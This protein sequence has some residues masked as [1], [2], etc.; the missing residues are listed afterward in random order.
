MTTQQSPLFLRIWE[1]ISGSTAFAVQNYYHSTISSGGVDYQFLDFDVD[2]LASTGNADA[3]DVTVTMPAL[4]TAVETASR[5]TGQFM[6]TLTAYWFEA[7]TAPETPPGGQ[8][9]LVQFVGL[10]SSWALPNFDS[11]LTLTI[12]SPLSPIVAQFPARRYSSAI[13]GTPCRL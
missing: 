4:T 7:D 6:A 9:T 10:L 13:I 1:P 5:G 8:T 11:D 2:S 3:N 12:G